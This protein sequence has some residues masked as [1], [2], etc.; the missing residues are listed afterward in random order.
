M[1]CWSCSEREAGSKSRPLRF[2][3]RWQS[4]TGIQKLLMTLLQSQPY[5]FKLVQPIEQSQSLSEFEVP[6]VL[7]L[8]Q[9]SR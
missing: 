6:V 2:G 7:D 5:P 9:F 4:R 3:S 1:S 8:I